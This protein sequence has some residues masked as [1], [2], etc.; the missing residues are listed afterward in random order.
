LKNIKNQVTDLPYNSLIY[1]LHITDIHGYK[2]IMKES[3]KYESDLVAI[4]GDLIKRKKDIKTIKEWLKN[5]KVP[6]IISSGNHD[7]AIDEGNWLYDLE[8]NNVFVHKKIEINGLK[9]DSR[10]FLSDEFDYD[11][12]ILIYHIPPNKTFTSIDKKLR[13][14]GDAY[15][16]ILLENEFN[17][18][19]VLCGHIHNPLKL[20][21]KVG[22][23]LIINSCYK[24]FNFSIV[25]S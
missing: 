10:P 23:S 9:I 12:D 18:K 15:L 22:K 16:R 13:D 2:K 8:D 19:F 1:I 11:T 17:P 5:F 3:L 6:V 24:K 14:F 21:D 25:E 4:S 20:K 7:M